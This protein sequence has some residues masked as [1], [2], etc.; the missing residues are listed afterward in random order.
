MSKMLT[1]NSALLL[2]ADVSFVINELEKSGYEAFAVGGCVRD[3]LR[4]ESP[5]DWDICTS[6][7]PEDTLRVF[8]GSNVIETGLKHGTV[9]V[10]LDHKPYE[11]TTYRSEG[12]YSDNRRPDTVSFLTDIR[13]DL[14]RRDFTINA[15]AYS[16][17]TGV[18]DFFGGIGDLENGVVKCVGDPDKRFGEDS[19]RIMRAMRFASTLKM[20]I[21]GETAKAML[22]N[23]A[24][25]GKI[26]AERIASELN[27]M[28]MGAYVYDVFSE[29]AQ[30]IFEIIPELAPTLNFAQDNPHHSFDVFTHTV[31][32]IAY[33]PFDLCVRLAL[34]FH[35]IAKP[36]CHTHEDGVSHFYGHAQ[37]SVDIA[38]S[39]LSR[40]K[41]D[42]ETSS[43]VKKLVLYHDS[44][45]LP[46]RKHIKRW[47]N[48]LGEAKLRQLM[49]VKRA[50]V[51]AQSEL[52]QN[53]RLKG[54]HDVSLVIDEILQE[55]QCFSLKDLAV[56][57]RDLLAAGIPQGRQIG[58]IMK[59]LLDLVI[60]EEIENS[61]DA[62]LSYVDVLRSK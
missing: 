13:G 57:G 38:R 33:A 22:H 55:Q 40:L 43:T 28:I 60:E 8:A 35:D 41:Y 26:S 62:L 47:L 24:L 19:L 11:I 23:R 2:P 39:V 4:G 16:A 48:R 12:E 59:L 10:I 53:E 45:M 6:A 54:L 27:K 52:K 46:S 25:L 44:D 50:D 31:L 29:H 61:K 30:I 37:V 7:L 56:D 9:T 14:S 58:E 1:Q 18:V 21:D 3:S 34:L 42:N 36:E 5:H 51:M 15:M 20:T 32:S 49:E 17:R